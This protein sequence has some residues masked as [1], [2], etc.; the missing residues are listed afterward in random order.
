MPSEIGKHSIV[1]SEAYLVCRRLWRFSSL[2]F[3]FFNVACR[4]MP[5][6]VVTIQILYNEHKFIKQMI[7][8][9]LSVFL[10]YYTFFFR[11]IFISFIYKFRVNLCIHFLPHSKGKGGNTMNLVILCVFISF[12]R[13]NNLCK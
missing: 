11:Y 10:C 6:L 2:F 12:I 7:I 8:P 1:F 13:F 5:V 3:L 4:R 9:N